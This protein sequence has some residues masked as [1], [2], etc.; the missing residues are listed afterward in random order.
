MTKQFNE[1]RDK[2]IDA[3]AI[4]AA[5]GVKPA[6]ENLETLYQSKTGKPDGLDQFIADKKKDLGL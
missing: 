1:K 4:A 6:R 2:T 5:L 3:L